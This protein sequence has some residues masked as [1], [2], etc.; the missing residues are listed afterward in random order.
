[1]PSS[2]ESYTLWG[3]SLALAVVVLGVVALALTM[4]LVTAN[5]IDAGAKQIWTIGKQVANA[6]IQLSLL[7]QTN[8]LVA[9]ILEAANGILHNALR[10]AR[11]AQ[12]C[13]GCPR[14]VVASATAPSRVQVG[15]VARPSTDPVGGRE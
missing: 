11:H 3:I 15:D 2:G 8:Q 6:T 12:S 7:K 1:M 14:C 5:R 4:I 13:A 9:D 10:I